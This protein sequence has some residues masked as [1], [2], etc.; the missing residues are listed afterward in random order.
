MAGEEKPAAERSLRQDW[1]KN[2]V[3]EGKYMGF[4]RG[5]SAATENFI[6]HEIEVDGK[7]YSVLESTVMRSAFIKKNPQRGAK[8]RLTYKG[9][10]PSKKPGMKPYKNFTLD[11]L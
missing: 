1:A 6:Y 11:L 9:E 7:M 8:I 2:P 5:R 10:V 3:L 4:S